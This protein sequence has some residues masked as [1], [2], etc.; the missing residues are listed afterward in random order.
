MKNVKVF[1]DGD[2]R[3]IK[4]K[5]V[6]VIGYGNQGQA[7]GRILKSNGASVIVG[8]IEDVCWDQAVKDFF[9]LRYW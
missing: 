9:C 3:L 4:D 1:L 8:N 6:S 7:Q 2:M 5:V